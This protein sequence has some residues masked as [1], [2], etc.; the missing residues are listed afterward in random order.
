MRLLRLLL[1]VLATAGALVVVTAGTASACSCATDRTGDFVESADEILA[2]TLVEVREPRALLFRSDDPVTYTLD[3]DAVYRGEVGEEVVFESAR[4]GASC[5]LEGMEVDRRYVVFLD[6]EGDQ[7]S[8]GLCGGTGPATA[9]LESELERLTGPP[10][11]P[12]PEDLPP[13][14]GSDDESARSAL[15][16]WALGAGAISLVGLVG[17]LWLRLLRA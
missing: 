9:A 6:L 8:A 13:G 2:G 14:G 4:D 7:R 17:T 15:P 16:A 1:T 5:G 12:T 11:E 10:A 3:V